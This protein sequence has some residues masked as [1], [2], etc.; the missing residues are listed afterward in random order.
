MKVFLSHSTKDQQF[1]EVLAVALKT[2]KIEPWI[3]GVDVEFG[4]NFVAEINEGLRE[5]DLAVLFWSPEATRSDWTRLGHQ[6]L[7]LHDWGRLE[8][9]MARLK[10]QEALCLALGDRSGLA[11]GYGKWGLLARAQRD[12]KAEQE[13]LSAALHIFSELNMARARDAVRE[14]LEKTERAT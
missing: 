8:E 2:E 13:K 12:R 10:K 7:I 4:R 9:A 3:C 11:H 5:A 14:E 6:A 1:V